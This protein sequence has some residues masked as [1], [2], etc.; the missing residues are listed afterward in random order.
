[1]KNI[2]LLIQEQFQ[3][4]DIK[5]E[6]SIF[7]RTI[8]LWSSLHGVLLTQKYQ[9]DFT[10]PSPNHLV[11]T[12]LIG[13][14]IPKSNLFEAQQKIAAQCDEALITSFTSLDTKENL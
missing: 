12:L 11:S 1:M 10:I 9:D 5:E 8:C 6:P 13:W 2:L 3:Q 14:G 7:T 4:L